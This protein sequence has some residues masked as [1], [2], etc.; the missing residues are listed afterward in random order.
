MEIVAVETN[1]K[2]FICLKENVGEKYISYPDRIKH[3]KF[4]GVIPEKTFMTGWYSIPNFDIPISVEEIHYPKKINYRFILKD[5]SMQSV[6]IPLEISYDDA[7]YINE[8]GEWWWN[9]NG[10]YA[11]LESLYEIIYDETEETTQIIPCSFDIIMKL[12]EINEPSYDFISKS[13]IEHQIVDKIMFPNIIMHT[14]PCKIS[15]VDLYKI[16]RKYIKQNINYDNAEITSDYDFCFAVNK[17]I[18]LAQPY[19]NKWEIKK[20]NGRSYAKPKFREE[21]IKSRKIPIFEMT[22]SKDKY[23]GYTPVPDIYAD[24][25]NQ[26]NERVKEICE[27]IIEKINKET[28][29]CKYCN[30]TGI[31]QEQKITIN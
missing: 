2:Y 24:N 21:Y 14:K 11:N 12:D 7:G 8:D 20:S 1:D 10:K 30:G 26:L 15:S 16:I 3:Y 17:I 5:E 31:E 6:N 13:N 25:E 4:N 28:I 18:K 19:T 22:N 9:N 27:T 29:E 23:K